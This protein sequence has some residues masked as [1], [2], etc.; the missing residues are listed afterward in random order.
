LLKIG[1]FCFFA[2]SLS[3]SQIQTGKGSFVMSGGFIGL[4]H[5]IDTE[6]TTYSIVEQHKNIFSSSWYYRYNFTWYDSDKMKQAQ[7]YINSYADGFHLP[8]TMMTTPSIEYRLQGLDLNIILGKDFTHKDENNYLGAGIMLG[9]SI[10]WI[11]SNK[12]SDNDDSTSDDTMELMKNSKTKIYTYK[13]GPSM[14]AMMSLN[15]FFALY[16]SAT[17]AYQTGSFKNDYI[18]S[19]LTVNGIFQEYDIGMRFQPVSADLHWGWIT[20]SPRLYATIGYRYSSWDLDDINMDITGSR[21]RFA[22]IDFNMNSS[23]GY[24]GLGYSF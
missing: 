24:V 2:T 12:D 4:T 14:T 17:Y 1:L 10:P 13:I 20:I 22:Q 5:S 23:V 3:G 21:I 15:R 8:P 19:D 11:E 16:G 9:V 18:R 7:Q 6:I